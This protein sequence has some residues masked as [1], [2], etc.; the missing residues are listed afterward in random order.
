MLEQCQC[1]ASYTYVILVYFCLKKHQTD[2]KSRGYKVFS[3]LNSA[4]HEIFN[5][6]KYKNIKKISFLGS[7]KPRMLFYLLLN[8][9]MPTTVGILTFIS[10]KSSM[11]S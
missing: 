2:A 5:A 11:L 6:H 3:M 1:Y 8:V 4:K 10:R 9:K 7:D